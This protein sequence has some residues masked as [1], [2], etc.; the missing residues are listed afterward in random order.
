MNS[1]VRSFRT[2]LEDFIRA[3]ARP[4]D[5]FSHQPRLYRL[6]KEIA[7]NQPCDDDILHAAAWLH[8]LGVFIGHRPEEIEALAAWDH[9]A[10]VT[11]EAPA[12]LER[13]GFPSAKIPAVL[14]AIRTHMPQCAPTSFEGVVLRDA[15]ILEQLGA[16]GI[17][18]T[19]SKV[20]RDTRFPC[21]GDA[22]RV[23]RQN[24][25]RLPGLIGLEAT[26]RLAEPRI[27]S[28][29]AFIESAETEAGGVEW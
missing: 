13:C 1:A 17:L 23:L 29:R 6:A 25:E 7:G 8:D 10:Y 19:V 24:L 22:V 27:L 21:F 12:I 5:K 26:R 9:V 14:E 15:D 20:G 16:V 11:R 28:L 3:Q 18:R 4:V 2:T